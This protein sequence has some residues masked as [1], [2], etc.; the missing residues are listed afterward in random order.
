MCGRIEFTLSERMH[1]TLRD[2]F[3][4]DAAWPKQPEISPTQQTVFLTREDA[5]T[6]HTGRWGLVP[7]GMDLQTAR[8]YA[9]FNARIE[10]VE[11][12]KSFKDAFRAGGRCV[13]PLSAFFEWPNKSKVRIARPDNRP[14]IAAGL[15]S[16]QDTPDGPLVSCTVMTRP[17]T[18]DLT[19]IHD[20]MPALLLT[21]DLDA[22]LQATPAEAKAVATGSWRPGLLTVAAAS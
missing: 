11:R 4:I 13:L 1:H 5:W 15:W 14:L 9:T 8:K 17:P 6:V 20:R 18:K 12:S 19:E 3:Q 22:W 7:P 21:K 10:T 2:T 16:Q